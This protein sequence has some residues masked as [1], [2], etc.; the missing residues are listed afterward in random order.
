MGV[1]FSHC[2]FSHRILL[3]SIW[4][5]HNPFKRQTDSTTLLAAVMN[6]LSNDCE[7]MV[8]EFTHSTRGTRKKTQLW[9]IEPLNLLNTTCL[10]PSMLSWDPKVSHETRAERQTISSDS[11]QESCDFNH[12]HGALA[13]GSPPSGCF[14]STT[15]SFGGDCLPPLWFRNLRF[16]DWLF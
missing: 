4:L 2:S 13:R 16:P 7:S 9:H 10:Q 12:S 11:H 8:I 1:V 5:M 15:Y 14:L 6:T 3:S